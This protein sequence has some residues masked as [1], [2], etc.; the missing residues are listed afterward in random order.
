MLQTAE[1][2]TLVMTLQRELQEMTGRTLFKK[3]RPFYFLRK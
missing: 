3:W 2:N 1:I